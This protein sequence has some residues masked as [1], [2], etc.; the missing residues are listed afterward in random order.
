MEERDIDVGET[1]TYRDG[2]TVYE[3][4]DVADGV[5]L[6][7]DGKI[8]LWRTKDDAF[9][10]LGAIERGCVFGEASVIR[11]EERTVTARSNGKSM[12]LFMPGEDFLKSVR[13]PLIKHL[14]TA[15]A[16]RLRERYI[17]K[18]EL[19]QQSETLAARKK[20]KTKRQNHTGEA[21]IEGVTP[22]VLG[23]M[24]DKIRVDTYPFTLGNTRVYGE[25]A[26]LT[27]QSLML[28]LPQAPDLDARHFE[29]IKRGKD[30]VVR[31]LGSKLGTVVNGQHI[32][33]YEKLSEM[34]LDAG[35]NTVGTGGR[36]SKVT[37][38]LT[39]PATD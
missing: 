28:P 37:F 25:M 5:F 20:V 34:V 35:E 16:E 17:P 36:A 8:D 24:T 23:V 9:H 22:L 6:V 11:G 38:L 14:V 12:L 32:S 29:L 27:E 19:L 18:R 15:M 3:E 1:R 13:D 10:F 7:L 2:E 33:K 30:I 4:G 39:L 31:D 26:R 21:I